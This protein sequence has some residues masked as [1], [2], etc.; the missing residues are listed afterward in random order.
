MDHA[1]R[2]RR[3][4]EG[5]F[6]QNAPAGAFDVFEHREEW[7]TAIVLDAC[8]FDAFAKVNRLPG[9]LAKRISVASCT[10]DWGLRCLDRPLADVVYISGSPYVSTWYLE[11]LGVERQLAHLEEVWRDGWDDT[12]HTVPPRAIADAFDRLYPQWPD[13]KFVLHFMQPHHPYIGPFRV[14]GAGWRKYFGAM[15]LDVPQLEGRTPIE[16]LEDGKASRE[17]VV[18][19]YESNLELVLGEVER[20]LHRPPGATGVSLLGPTGV[21]PVGP[22]EAQPALPRPV[23]VTADHGEAFGESGVFGHPCGTPLPE[24]LEVPYL[25]IE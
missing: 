12:L 13:K 24:L 3:L 2:L 7:R 21:S 22:E 20:L 10:E 1:E 6:L 16:M 17:E 4:E 15:E 11:Q 5:Y 18:R 14:R 25:V 19:A 23:V 9:T 8:R